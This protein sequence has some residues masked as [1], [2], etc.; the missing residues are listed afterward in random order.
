M[1]VI[2]VGFADMYISQGSVEMHLCCGN[3]NF[4]SHILSLSGAEVPYV[5]LSFPGT[6][7][8]HSELTL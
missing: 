2:I 3:W 8:P 1:F 7:A 4:P 5:E 6:F